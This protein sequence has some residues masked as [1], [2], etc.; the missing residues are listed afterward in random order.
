M[1]DATSPVDNIKLVYNFTS[2]RI[3]RPKAFRYGRRSKFSANGEDRA[4]VET[5][6]PPDAR[7]IITWGRIGKELDARETRLPRQLYSWRSVFK[8]MKSKDLT[9]I[10][11]C[12]GSGKSSWCRR[13][14]IRAQLNGVSVAGLISPAIYER[15]EKVG[16]AL[17]DLNSGK[18]RVLASRRQ[19]KQD[20]DGC[21]WNFNQETIDWANHL[22]K[23]VNSKDTLFIDE[24]G[25]M[26]LLHNLGFQAG[27][28]LIDEDRYAKAYVVVRPSLLYLVRERWP[29]ARVMDL[30][31]NAR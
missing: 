31:A 15:G 27:L 28:A 20:T 30:E 17:V 19:P 1:G 13:T 14:A 29:Q 16:I 23:T 11:G 18:R 24:L 7:E 5:L 8:P 2:L 4:R 10:T 3:F 12:S 26:E 9:L 21:R 25:P 6:W 22:L